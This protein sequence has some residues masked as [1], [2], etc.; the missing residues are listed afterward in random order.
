MESAQESVMVPSRAALASRSLEA[1]A[2]GLEEHEKHHG[3]AADELV[4]VVI[5]DGKT[6]RRG[7]LL[8]MRSFRRSAI[9]Q[10]SPW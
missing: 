4:I 8:R 6:H 3:L 5:P 10:A 1:A 9:A 7:T 2:L